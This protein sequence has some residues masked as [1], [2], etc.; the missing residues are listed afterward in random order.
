MI[1]VFKDY[2]IF[3]KNSN[4]AFAILESVISVLILSF[5]ILTINMFLLD[6]INFL[7]HLKI[8]AE[9]F[10]VNRNVTSCLSVYHNED[11][12]NQLFKEKMPDEK[13]NR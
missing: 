11:L 3:E 2:K 13:K 1:V 10:T 5:Y 12:C 7:F 6:V 9:N 4:R 8:I